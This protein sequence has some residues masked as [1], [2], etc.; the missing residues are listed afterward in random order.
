M[1]VLYITSTYIENSLRLLQF[2]PLSSKR[3][4]KDSRRIGYISLDGYLS[5][6]LPSSWCSKFPSGVISLL[7]E[8][9]PL[10]FV[11]RTY[12]LAMNSHRF[13]SFEQLFH[14]YCLFL[15]ELRFPW[16]FACWIILDYS[17]DI[18]NI[19]LQESDFCLNLLDS[20]DVFLLTTDLVG[21]RPQVTAS[22]L[23]VVVP[24]SVLF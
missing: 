22:L 16:F 3:I 18:L 8:E 20:V 4:L 5:F 7:F 24:T 13:P 2:L 17:L 11:F 23:C 1:V 12:L 21:F 14:L 9:L 10:L 15:G 19:V 6:A